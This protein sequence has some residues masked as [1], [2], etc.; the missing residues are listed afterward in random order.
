MQ[1]AIDLMRNGGALPFSMFGYNENSCAD[2]PNED[3]KEVAKSFKIKGFNHL[4]KGGD[5]Y[6]TDL[7]A[8][9]QNLALGA[10]VVIGM[11]VGGSFMS[12][13]NGEKAWIPNNSDYNLSGFGRH[14]LC[15]IGYDD[16]HNGGSFQIM[17]SWGES[18]GENGIFWIHYNVFDFFTREAYGLYPMGDSDVTTTS[19]LDAEIALVINSTGQYIQLTHDN[20]QLF[21]TTST[22]SKNTDFKIEITNSIECYI[23]LLEK[24]RTKAAMCFSLTL[25]NTRPTAELL[26]Q[27]YSL[28]I[29]HFTPT[30]Q[31]IMIKLP[32]WFLFRNLTSKN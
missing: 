6:Q 13:M 25:P 4:T 14:A 28:R 18:W 22:V 15:V 5:N 9:K 3:E 20:V 27:G 21:R 29:I 2:R 19:I 26:E 32:L 11:M 24:K 7:L 16:Y 30:K 31:A 12:D 1:K 23:Y 8:I 10:P 17:N